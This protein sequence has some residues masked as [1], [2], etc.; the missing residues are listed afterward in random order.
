VLIGHYPAAS[1]SEL[2]VQYDF[3]LPSSRP[4]WQQAK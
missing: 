1:I 4:K 3:E 2:P